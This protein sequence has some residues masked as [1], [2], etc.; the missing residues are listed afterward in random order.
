MTWAV[1]QPCTSPGQKLTLLMLAN[2]CNDESG[3]CTL[4]HRVLAAECSMG[5]STLKRHLQALADKKLL[6]TIPRSLD[7][8]SMSNQYQLNLSAKASNLEGVT[9]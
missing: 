9:A 4:S 7:G 3:Q 1:E 2:H 5:V 6:T 8:G